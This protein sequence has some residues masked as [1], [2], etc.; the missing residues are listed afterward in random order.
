MCVL[1]KVSGSIHRM[2]KYNQ[3]NFRDARHGKLTLANKKLRYN[4]FSFTNNELSFGVLLTENH[5][6]NIL[7]VLTNM[8][9]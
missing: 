6:H 3:F 1:L 9:Y 4:S 8:S 2:D 7:R 5:P